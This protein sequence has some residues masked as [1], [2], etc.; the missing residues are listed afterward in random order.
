[1]VKTKD[2]AML[3]IIDSSSLKEM[4]E[5]KEVAGKLNI[6]MK[7]MHDRGEKMKVITPSSNL[8]RAISQVDPKT[9]IKHL[10]K[11]ISYLDVCPSLADHTNK[12]QCMTEI[13]ALA[14]VICKKKKEAGKSDDK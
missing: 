14:E 10:Q 8:L 4:I 9:P 2:I 12:E 11:I 6:K 13:M 7:E 5:G 3:A 1:M